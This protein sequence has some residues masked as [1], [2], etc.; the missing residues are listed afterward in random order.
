[1]VSGM[2]LFKA[3]SLA[4]KCTFLLRLRAMSCGHAPVSVST[5]DVVHS[6]TCTITHHCFKVSVPLW[7]GPSLQMLLLSDG[8]SLS[9]CLMTQPRMSR[10]SSSLIPGAN[11]SHHPF[12]LLHMHICSCGPCTSTL[13]SSWRAFRIHTYHTVVVRL[14]W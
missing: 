4:I 13:Y 1:M 2:A 6:A 5:L 7:P 3:L 14:D 12:Q 11:N 9:G 8:P 10:S